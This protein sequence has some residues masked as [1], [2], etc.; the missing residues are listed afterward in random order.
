M[1]MKMK[2]KMNMGME[3]GNENGNGYGNDGEMNQ[4]S[5]PAVAGLMGNESVQYPSSVAGWGEGGVRSWLRGRAQRAPAP[6][7]PGFFPAT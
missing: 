5:T 6:H 1:K 4:Y 7:L 2:M 3:L